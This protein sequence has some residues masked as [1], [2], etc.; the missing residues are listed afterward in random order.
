LE[1]DEA[2]KHDI[3]RYSTRPSE[4][5]GSAGRWFTAQYS[6]TIWRPMSFTRYSL[7]TGYPAARSKRTSASPRNGLRARPTCNGPVGFAL[8]CSSRTRSFLAGEVPY[9]SPSA[10]T[11]VRTSSAKGDGSTV[12]FTYGPSCRNG[13]NGATGFTRDARA[14]MEA[15]A[16]FSSFAHAWAAR[17]NRPRSAGAS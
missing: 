8:V 2:L 1:G 17:A 3:E 10:R 7:V 15:G 11:A 4:S 6:K 16:S 5:D 13:A 14:A 12:K 9:V